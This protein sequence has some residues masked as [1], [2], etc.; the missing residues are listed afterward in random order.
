MKKLLCFAI[1]LLLPVLAHTAEPK[2]STVVSSYRVWV[3][4]GH[5]DA[6]KKGL[7]A[8]AQKYHTGAWKWRV[9]EVLTGPDSGAFQFSEG[10]NT[11]TAIDDRGDLG[12][13]HG[14]HYDTALT[15][16]I[17]KSSPEAYS[18][19]QAD[20]STTAAGNWSN[21]VVMTHAFPKPGRI[22]PYQEL[23]KMN[24]AVAEKLGDNVVVWSRAV[25]GEPQFVSVWRLKHGFKDLESTGTTYKSSFEEVHGAGSWDKYQE[26]Y[27]RVI[28]RRY[29]ETMEFKPELS[30]K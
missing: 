16:H 30:S 28:D 19:Y 1:A 2:P 6:F 24:K 26:E 9:Y 20:Y 22:A 13:E 14:K 17:E 3:K 8:H 15:P 7:T 10:P 4:D 21:K 12:K 11:W 5:M 18:S 29:T 27:A 25:S 23:L